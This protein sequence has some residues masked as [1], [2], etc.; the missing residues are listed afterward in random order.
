MT[1]PVPIDPQVLAAVRQ[2]HKNCEAN[3]DR[4][5]GVKAAFVE[6]VARGDRADEEQQRATCHDLIDGE[7]DQLRALGLVLATAIEKFEGE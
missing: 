7:L 2:A 5:M 4:L 1:E 6:A 3:E